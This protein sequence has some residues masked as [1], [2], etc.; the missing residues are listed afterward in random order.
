MNLI[1]ASHNNHKLKE[2]SEILNNKNFL[3]QSLNNIGWQSE[4]EENGQSFA[5]NAVLKISPFLQLYPDKFIFADDSG[6]EV[7][8]LGGAP[9]IH[10]ARYSGND[11]SSLALCQKLL[12]E[13]EGVT[14][15]EAKFVTVVALHDPYLNDNVFF[16]G[17]IKGVITDKMMGN[18]GFGYDPVFWVEEKQKTMA[19]MSAF[20]KNKLS[21]RYQ[22]IQ[23]M[24]DYLLNY[25]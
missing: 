13:L 21:H 7:E 3:L 11:R 5:E 23:K 18:E 1:F 24:K 12:G 9:G 25:V 16:K 8:A 4:I 2:V 20:E 17:E 22:A 6:L 10:S 19:E 15:R 14:K